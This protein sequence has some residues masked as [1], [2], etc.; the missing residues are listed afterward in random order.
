MRFRSRGG[1]TLTECLVT[2]F[3]LAVGVVGV[4]S[5]FVYASL[6][7]RKAAYTAQACNIADQTLE[8]VRAQDYTAFTQPSGTMTIATP[9]LPGGTGV[10]AWQPY[11][12]GASDT[13]LRVIALN[14]SWRWRG[15]ARGYY[16]LT[17]LVR[18][19]EGG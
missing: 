16:R 10:L 17:T 5:M 2:V 12:S 8:Q 11:P 13:G 4:A 19:P 9:G 7:E 6:S 1:F 15:P 18:K 14:L 3:V